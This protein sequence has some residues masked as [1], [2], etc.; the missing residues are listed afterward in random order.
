MSL[1]RVSTI[2][3]RLAEHGI[4]FGKRIGLRPGE[5]AGRYRMVATAAAIASATPVHL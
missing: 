2:V 4:E 3:L 5:Y 1:K